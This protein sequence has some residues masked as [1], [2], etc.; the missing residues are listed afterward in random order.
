LAAVGR[1]DGEPTG[2]SRIE[3]S[4]ILGQPDTK[5]RSR[6]HRRLYVT[7]RPVLGWRWRPEQ[8]DLVLHGPNMADDS[9]A[10]SPSLVVGFAACPGHWRPPGPSRVT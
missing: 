2:L 4:A 7:S 1:R 9:A 6:A 3:E 8:A 5:S 10:T